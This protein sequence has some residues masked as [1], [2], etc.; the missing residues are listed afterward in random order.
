MLA[1]AFNVASVFQP[2]SG[3]T[4]PPKVAVPLNYGTKDGYA[5]FLKVGPLGNAASLSMARRS[6]A[7]PGSF[8]REGMQVYTHPSSTQQCPSDCFAGP[9]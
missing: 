1:P 7:A 4:P 3:L 2:Q 5:F 9:S 8:D 6:E